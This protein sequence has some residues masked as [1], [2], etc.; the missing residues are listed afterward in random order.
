VDNFVI[1]GLTGA[2]LAHDFKKLLENGAFLTKE[3]RQPI[4]G[5]SMP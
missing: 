2:K 1:S 4:P 5:A 3:I